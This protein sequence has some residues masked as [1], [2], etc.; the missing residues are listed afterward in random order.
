MDEISPGEVSQRRRNRIP[1]CI[2]V[3]KHHPRLVGQLSKQ[4]H[5][6]ICVLFERL[7]SPFE[8]TVPAIPFASISFIPR[9]A[10]YSPPSIC[11]QPSGNTRSAQAYP[12]GRTPPARPDRTAYQNRGVHCCHAYKSKNCRQTFP[13]YAKSTRSPW[14]RPC[15]FGAPPVHTDSSCRYY[16]WGTGTYS[17]HLKCGHLPARTDK[18]PKHRR[19]IPTV[20]PD[21]KHHIPRLHPLQEKIRQRRSRIPNVIK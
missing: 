3:V 19:V 11:S 18:P 21:I 2:E 5:E 12:P 8:I 14:K 4:S 7:P 1:F 15:A 13:T 9:N 10:S 6:C 16:P 17:G 20:C